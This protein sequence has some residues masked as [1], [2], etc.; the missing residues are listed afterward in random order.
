M[1]TVLF[2]ASGDWHRSF[3]RERR[4]P[5]RIPG[6]NSAPVAVDGAAMARRFEASLLHFSQK[7]RSSAVNAYLALQ[8]V[9]I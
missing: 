2:S 3:S 4:I 1:R 5:V 9:D 7:Q 6:L 8:R